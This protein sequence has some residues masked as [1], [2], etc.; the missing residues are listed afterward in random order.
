MMDS[1]LYY[2]SPKESMRH[3]LIEGILTPKEVLRL[4]AEGSLE[5]AVLGVSSG[6]DS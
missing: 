6:M 4:I 2:L 1:M 5:S 3:I